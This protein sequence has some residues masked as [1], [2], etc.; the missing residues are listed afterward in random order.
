MYTQVEKSKENNN[1]AVANSVSQKKNNLKQG[2]GFVDNRPEAVAQRK[3]KK[4]ADNYSAQQQQSVQKK[5]NNT[6]L[7]DN[8]KSGIENLSGYSMD[9][10]KVHYNSNKPAQL[11]AHA[12]A[13][14]TNIHLGPGQEK[15]LQH[16]AWH[17]VQ[18]K[19]GRVQPTMHT[20]GV[21]INDNYALE[22]EAD[23][24]GE[25]AAA[26][27]RTGKVGIDQNG[28][29]ISSGIVQKKQIKSA[30]LE[31]ELKGASVAKG[32]GEFATHEK[33]I[34]KGNWWI[35]VDSYNP[36]L[37][38]K[39]TESKQTLFGWLALGNA[40]LKDV[41]LL[42]DKK[43][44]LALLPQGEPLYSEVLKG[45]IATISARLGLPQESV[46]SKS[47]DIAYHAKPQISFGIKKGELANFAGNVMGP[48][49]KYTE[50]YTKTGTKYENTDWPRINA[51]VEKIYKSSPIWQNAKGKEFLQKLA[52]A[53]NPAR[54]LSLMTVITLLFSMR[55]QDAG[56]IWQY[57]KA[58]FSVLPR[59]PLS[60]LFDELE[61]EQ[62]TEYRE[63]MVL[64]VAAIEANNQ[65]KQ[66]GDDDH[67]PT[68]IYKSNK[69]N[70]TGIK[71]QLNSIVSA[72]KRKNKTREQGGK[73]VDLISSD[74]MASTQNVGASVGM[75][76]LPDGSD[77]IYE[78]RGMPYV[79]IK[80]YSN[81]S[82]IY[83]E[84][85]AAYGGMD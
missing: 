30:G 24:E 5:E 55:K 58:R 83:Q 65:D 23:V 49:I 75:L 76:D 2:F 12:Y 73:D 13:Q 54:G 31:L 33:V 9:D 43:N 79:N 50:G 3:M 4:M 41:Q 61:D 77:G 35:E 27:G 37:V 46:V 62:E 21:S 19:Q 52:L 26:Q 60:A 64:W 38:T 71:S 22:R 69:I 25:K 63:L 8:I 40:V 57:Y 85:I 66:E 39:P 11:Q 7:P 67:H 45:E 78:I 10:V 44:K 68:K 82:T 56:D 16:E 80:N 29:D 70:H 48:K 84:T 74:D 18:Q 59:V 34:D 36:E 14:G 6:G 81:V 32:V 28:G 1:R 51:N 47:V 72:E 20:K 15:H 42:A 53:S 17:V